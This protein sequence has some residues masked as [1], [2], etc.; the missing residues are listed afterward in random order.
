MSNNVKSYIYKICIVGDGGVG[1][2]SIVLKYTENTF[3]ENYI[4][5]I[6]ANFAMKSIELPEKPDEEITL[7]IWDLAGQVHFHAV[8]PLFYTGV[9]ALIYVFDITHK[10]SLF[11]LLNWKT[12]V[13]ESVG[14]KPCIL[15]GNKLDLVKYESEKVTI[16]EANLVKKEINAFS[17]F[18]TSA[19]SGFNIEKAFKESVRC[20]FK[21]LKKPEDYIKH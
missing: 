2:T 13:E 12:E 3:K 16:E 14:L 8:T 20:I 5:T 9:R 4:L 10:K 18:E 19:K 15:I 7:Q 17:Y 1:K 11:N 21:N 6:G